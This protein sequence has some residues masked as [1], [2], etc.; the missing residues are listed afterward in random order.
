MMIMEELAAMVL[1]D[2]I[3]SSAILFEAQ[4]VELGRIDDEPEGRILHRSV[5]RESHGNGQ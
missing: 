2:R 5:R 4:D 3:S 1:S